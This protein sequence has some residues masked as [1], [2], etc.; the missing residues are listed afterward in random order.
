MKVEE[1]IRV[2]EK[3]PGGVRRGITPLTIVLLGI[4]ACVLFGGLYFVQELFFFVG[5]AALLVFFAGSLYLLGI[6]AYKAG[7]G[8]LGLFRTVKPITASQG[9]HS[10]RTAR[11]FFSISGDQ[12]SCGE[13]FRLSISKA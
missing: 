3:R 10:E 4:V 6:L 9:T 7:Q 11:R 1:Q 5:L 13:W 12:S 2:K 8:I